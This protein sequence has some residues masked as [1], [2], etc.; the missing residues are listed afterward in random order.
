MIIRC[1]PFYWKKLLSEIKED[2]SLRQYKKCQESKFCLTCFRET[3]ETE[4]HWLK[5]AKQ[6]FNECA[7]IKITKKGGTK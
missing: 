1:C 2:C 4:T 5:T 6:W 7:E 3:D